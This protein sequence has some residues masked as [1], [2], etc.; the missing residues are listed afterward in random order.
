MQRVPTRFGEVVKMN[1]WIPVTERMPE[2]EGGYIVSV[3][4]QEGP[5]LSGSSLYIPERGFTLDYVTA[6]MPIPEP[7]NPEEPEYTD[8]ANCPVLDL[9]CYEQCRRNEKGDVK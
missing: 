2:K 4:Y 8:C 6:W 1:R 5:R 7:Y 3:Q 9:E